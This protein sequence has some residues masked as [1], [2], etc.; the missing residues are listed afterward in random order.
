MN[1]NK[2]TNNKRRT[3]GDYIE[4]LTRGRKKIIINKDGDITKNNILSIWES[5]LPMVL[6]RFSDI[7]FL[8]NYEKGKQPILERVGTIREDINSK[9]VENRASEIIDF[10]TNYQF[11]KGIYYVRRDEKDSKIGV[12]NDIFANLGKS[13]LDVS[14][15]RWLYTCGLGYRYVRIGKSVDNPLIIKTLDPRYTGKVIYND[16]EETE[17]FTY[18]MLS[19]NPLLNVSSIYDCTVFIYSNT[20]SCIINNGVV[21][22]WQTFK[23]GVV[24]NPII[25]YEANADRM[26]SFQRVLPL[27]DA[28]N[29]LQSDRLNAVNQ[30]VQS[31]MIFKNINIDMDKITEFKEMGALKITSLDGLD[32]DVK[33]LNDELDQTYVQTLKNDLINAINEICSLPD[34]NGAGKTS[35]DTGSAVAMRDGWESAETSAKQLD[36]Y[37]K[38]SEYK[39]LNIVCDALNYWGDELTLRD[40]AWTNLDV[41]DIDIKFLRNPRI[42]LTT[43]SNALTTMMKNGIDPKEALNITE[44]FPDVETVYR[45]SEE[46]ML[47]VQKALIGINTQERTLNTNGERELI[48]NTEETEHE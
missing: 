22:N 25:E 4:H 39:M 12:I 9:I 34:R 37:F 1:N 17:V 31:Y 7:N 47:A 19:N 15:T 35:G 41:K 45:K 27:L 2:D 44:L 40:E 6:E 38:P 29:L 24:H 30:F 36:A 10:K 5:I 13:S 18:T 3:K 33:L 43:S 20:F 46:M 16:I 11:G 42:D 26:G 14:L 8:Y 28:I 48:E 21:E 32:A 23:D